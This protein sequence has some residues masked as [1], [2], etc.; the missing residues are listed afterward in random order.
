M[1]FVDLV[2]DGASR[3]F[4]YR[5]GT[6][7]EH[8][9]QQIF[10]NQH[11]KLHHL[12]RNRELLAYLQRMESEGRA[13]I[14]VDAGANIGAASVYFAHV[15][16]RAQIVAIEPEPGNFS[17]LEENV[18]GLHVVCIRAALAS[19]AGRTRLSDPGIGHWGYRTDP[20]A[21]GADVAQLT[22]HQILDEHCTA[23]RFPFLVKVDIEGGEKDLFRVDTGWVERFPLLLVELHDWLLP[24]QGTAL[25]LLRCLSGLDRDFVFAGE[26][27]ASIDNRLD[28]P[29]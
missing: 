12:A 3:R 24:R 9:L 2:I 14:I 1:T 17:L 23:D 27:V 21:Q 7:D 28:A 5:P 26:M 16:P 4:Q 13:P 8:V 11:Y 6:S 29:R 25:P 15:Y 19:Q 18:K 20:G 10:G 22:M